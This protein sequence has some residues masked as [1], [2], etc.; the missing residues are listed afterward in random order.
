[1]PQKPPMPTVLTIRIKRAWWVMPLLRTCIVLSRCATS[2]RLHLSS[3][4][5]NRWSN[6]IGALLA[7][8]H[9]YDCVD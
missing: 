8:G 3:D 2:L 7:R 5:E 1:M 4:A 6:R 9:T